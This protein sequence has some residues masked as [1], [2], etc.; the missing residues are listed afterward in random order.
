V[1]P[2]L[3]FQPQTEQFWQNIR[4][5]FLVL[6]MML[7]LRPTYIPQLGLII[8]ENTQLNKFIRNCFWLIQTSLLRLSFSPFSHIMILCKRLAWYWILEDRVAY[9]STNFWRWHITL[10][11]LLGFWILSI[12]SYL[13][14]ARRSR[15]GTCFL[16]GYEGLEEP[17]SRGPKERL[18]KVLIGKPGRKKSHARSSGSLAN[19]GG[20]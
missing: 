2:N 8:K 7:I 18:Y 14:L 1:S 19:L 12:A 11:G 17:N 5:L 20:S 4:S 10:L 9:S 16:A 3:E 6:L 13:K 15:N